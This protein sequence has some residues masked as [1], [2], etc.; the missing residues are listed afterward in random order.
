MPP[1][2]EYMLELTM[3][4]TAACWKCGGGACCG[5]RR[6]CIQPLG[7]WSGDSI[8]E[9]AGAMPWE[10]LHNG[11]SAFVNGTQFG[12]ND[13][14]CCCCCPAAQGIK[15]AWTHKVR[16]SGRHSW[17]GALPRQAAPF[18]ASSLHY[19]HFYFRLLSVWVS[20]Q[21]F[22]LLW[23]FDAPRGI[24]VPWL[25]RYHWEFRQLVAMLPE[26]MLC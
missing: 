15:H 9:S 21:T 23:P 3:A 6:L 12:E 2:W 4:W 26:E 7:A 22:Y 10:M 19:C 20:I 16:A 14:Y 17:M 1:A 13:C 8:V 18:C 5:W 11:E 25:P 24:F